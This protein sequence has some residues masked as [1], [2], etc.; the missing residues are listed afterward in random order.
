[1]NRSAGAPRK[2]F[3]SYAR[4]D[5]EFALRLARDLQAEGVQVWIDTGIQGGDDWL[6]HIDEGLRAS[7][8]VLLIVSPASKA[9]QWVRKE[10]MAAFD[11]QIPV[12][13]VLRRS[14][15][16]WPLI[17]NLQSIDF[18]GSYEEGFANLMN[19]QPPRRTWRRW[20]RVVL[21]RFRD[22]IGRT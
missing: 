16:R 21:S 12:T 18:R 1:M 3:I 2:V 9:S 17:N 13:P 5:R 6:Q 15:G 11:R 19:R 20:I 10:L 8:A 14:C 4:E 22:S 7:D